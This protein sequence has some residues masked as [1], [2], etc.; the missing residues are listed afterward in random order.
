M[1]A[2]GGEL[3]TDSEQLTVMVPPDEVS[4]V[5]INQSVYTSLQFKVAAVTEA[6]EGLFSE[7]VIGGNIISMLIHATCY[8]H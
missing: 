1:V 2:V 7:E 8:S 4:F 3:V 6:G 5:L